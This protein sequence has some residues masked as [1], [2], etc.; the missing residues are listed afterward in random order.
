M[1]FASIVKAAQSRGTDNKY[2]SGQFG[3]SRDKGTRK[4]KGLD[5]KAVPHEAVFSPLDGVIV[6]ECVPYAPFTGLLIRGTGEHSG[7]EVKLFYVQGLACGP[8]KAGELVGAAED[9]SVKYPGITNHV[10]LEIR[11]NGKVVPPLDFYEM[12]F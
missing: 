10:H 4:H 6:R 5:V 11:K 12:C 9:L 2:G 7:Y 1:A 8:V 3:A